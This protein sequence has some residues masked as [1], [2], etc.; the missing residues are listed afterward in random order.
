M[1]QAS[2]NTEE[3]FVMHA[4]KGMFSNLP[5]GKLNKSESPDFIIYSGRKKSIG[6]E[7]TRFI[8]SSISF[9]NNHLMKFVQSETQALWDLQFKLPIVV[10]LSF[11]N[12]IA[13]SRDTASL[14]KDLVNTAGHY[15]AEMTQTSGSIISVR[16]ELLPVGVEDMNL[17]YNINLRG[18]LWLQAAK[19]DEKSFFSATFHDLIRQKEEK[20]FLYRKKILEAYWLLIY[21]DELRI[22]PSFSLEKIIDRVKIT[23]RFDRLF[24]VDLFGNR[25]FELGG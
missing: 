24:F 22:P 20:L 25:Y 11:S 17:F 12:N 6:I 23:T 19:A 4:F 10:F 5:K 13:E 9:D 2:K 8:D 7:I 16:K 1:V 18:S 3:W 21:T 15:V 14:P